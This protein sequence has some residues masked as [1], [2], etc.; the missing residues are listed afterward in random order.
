MNPKYR[1]TCP[2]SILRK[3]S[4]TN[5]EVSKKKKTQKTVRFQE[6]EDIIGYG[7]GSC[8]FI[9]APRRPSSI[10][11]LFLGIFLFCMILLLAAGL[12]YNSRRHKFKV[13]E[14]VHSQLVIVIFQIRH[15]ALK[16]WTWFVRQ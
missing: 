16:C 4:S 13:L 2:P 3:T 12:Y 8:D 10:S 11:P 9:V 14:E 5:Q 15:V 7:G 6:K 1:T